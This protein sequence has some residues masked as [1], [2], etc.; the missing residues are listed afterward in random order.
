[1]G[2]FVSIEKDNTGRNLICI[3]FT[4]PVYKRT[5][6]HETETEGGLTISSSDLVE[7]VDEVQFHNIVFPYDRIDAVEIE[8]IEN[9]ENCD[10][11]VHIYRQ[12]RDGS[13]CFGVGTLD[14][15]IMIRN[16]ILGTAGPVFAISD[17]RLRRNA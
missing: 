14:E 4:E 10:W 11:L 13:F 3:V 9:T 2:K 15:A 12:G 6:T 5:N 7:S 8:R 16:T 17:A 1:M